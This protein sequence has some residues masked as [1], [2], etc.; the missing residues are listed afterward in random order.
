MLAGALLREAAAGREPVAGPR[1][2]R[3][4]PPGGRAMLRDGLVVGRSRDAALRVPLPEVSREHA[5]IVATPDGFAIA[6]LGS[7]NGVAVNG[8]TVSASPI[9][10]R[11]GDVIA[12]G[13]ARLRVDGLAPT[14]VAP[15]PVASAPAVA[16]EVASAS[17]PEARRATLAA[18][19]LAAALG[20]AAL[21][22]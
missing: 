9:A 16:R 19:L 14:V 17:Q 22:L 7:K 18:V 8:R 5:R 4:D 13:A 2:I 15:P 10:L 21:A 11:D 3:I 1:L 20:L 12:L 6:D